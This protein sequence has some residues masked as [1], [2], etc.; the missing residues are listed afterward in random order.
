MNRRGNSGGTTFRIF[1]PQTLEA[2][3]AKYSAG[4]M[5]TKVK[6]VEN[7]SCQ[8]LSGNIARDDDEPKVLKSPAT[9]NPLN[10]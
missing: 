3:L 6:P 9:L 1:Q 10:P 5:R 8:E 4:G 7:L 2:L